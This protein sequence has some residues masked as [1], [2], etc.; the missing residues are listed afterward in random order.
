MENGGFERPGKFQ[1]G[2]RIPP[3]KI[4]GPGF[5]ELEEIK[6]SEFERVIQIS[7]DLWVTRGEV[8]G[9]E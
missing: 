5:G 8:I 1:V 2:F 7:A 3:G 6:S 9:R 4:K